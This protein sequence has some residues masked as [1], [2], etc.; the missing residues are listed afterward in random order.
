MRHGTSVATILVLASSSVR[1]ADADA[2]KKP[3]RIEVA[4]TSNGFEPDKIS[5]KK[6]EPIMFVFTRKVE[7]TCTKE[8]ILR[9]SETQ[10]IEKKLPLNTPVEIAATFAKAGELGY[11]CG[12]N[13]HTGVI[14]VL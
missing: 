1:L 6:G 12:M 8:V 10:K 9:V 3:R 4:I 7:K 5:V 2:K 11:A 14:S 13:M